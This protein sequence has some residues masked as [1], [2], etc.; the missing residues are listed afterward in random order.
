MTRYNDN[1]KMGIDEYREESTKTGEGMRLNEGV[2]ELT[3][4]RVRQQTRKILDA[5]ACLLKGNKEPT[6]TAKILE[7]LQNLDVSIPG[8]KA[9]N[10]L[11]AISSYSDDFKSHGR[12]GWTYIGSK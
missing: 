1:A 12:P 11:S 10:N 5:V 9:Q 3:R 8:D 2:A 7:E 6:P 4:S